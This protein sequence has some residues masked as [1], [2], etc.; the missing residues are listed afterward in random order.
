MKEIS[1]ILIIAFNAQNILSR[2]FYNQFFILLL[3][4]ILSSKFCL[5]NEQKIVSIGGS[6]TEI[7]YALEQGN[8]IVARD[9]TSTYPKETSDIPSIGYMRSLSPEAILSTKTNLILAE[10]GSGPKTT[11]DIL[12]SSSIKIILISNSYSKEGIINKIL[13][14]GETLKSE[15]KAQKLAE[16]VEKEMDEIQQKIKSY[17]GNKKKVLFILSTRG[18][19]ILAA[20]K[21]TAANAIIELSG[22]QNSINNFEGYKILNDEAILSASP[23]VV[24]MMDRGGE[25][26]VEDEKLFSLPSL[27]KTPAAKDL[28]IIR[29]DG[30]YMLGFGPRTATAIRDLNKALYGKSSERK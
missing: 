20:G 11:I 23:E 14:V 13:T 9:S 22:G 4:F 10:E 7:I 15:T 5:S 8:K 17:K 28:S 12:I 18:G 6:I 27:K 2:I 24:I 1:T 29:M 21:N 26:S 30:L 3:I 25:H 16:K 19:K